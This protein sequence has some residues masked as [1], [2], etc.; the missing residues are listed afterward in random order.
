MLATATFQG[1]LWWKPVT[2]KNEEGLYQ[3]ADGSTSE[4]SKSIWGYLQILL[5]DN[6]GRSMYQR[7]NIIANNEMAEY[8]QKNYPFNFTDM[9]YFSTDRSVAYE[10]VVSC[11]LQPA[12]W[13]AC[14]GKMC[15]KEQWN[16]R[17]IHTCSITKEQVQELTGYV[18]E[19]KMSDLDIS[20]VDD[21]INTDNDWGVDE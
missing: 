5:K 9:K 3:Y 6:Q 8:I 1:Y 18:K 21:Y 7:I 12:R 16:I 14:N 4:Y 17:S 19:E 20:G 13:R 11:D 10:V 2:K 15:S